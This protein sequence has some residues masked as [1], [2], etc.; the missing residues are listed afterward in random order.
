[1]NKL[2][3]IERKFLVRGNFKNDAHKATRIIQGYLLI[4]PERS[5][6]IR[7]K[8]IKGYITI[9]GKKN[10]S[11][12]SRFEWEKEIPFDEALELI[13]LC[14]PG[15]ID[16]TRYEVKSGDHIIEIDEFHVENEGLII[17][18][19]ELKHENDTFK[20]PDWLGKEVTGDD[21]YYNVY[22]K[23]RPFKTWN[24]PDPDEPN[25]QIP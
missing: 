2:I 6:R 13:K 21:K 24:S 25:F 8:G 22:L 5:V 4:S 7:L 16:K 1:M 19:I 14:E 3:E 15:V 11:G 20:K 9:K 17:A 18:E 10:D 23:N 12:L